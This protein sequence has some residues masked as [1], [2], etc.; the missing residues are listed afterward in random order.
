MHEGV[1]E[2][3]VK[4]VGFLRMKDAQG[5]VVGRLFVQRAE[6]SEFAVSGVI[7]GYI[8]GRSG[9]LIESLLIGR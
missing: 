9:F 3:K 6:E 1:N 7:V 8:F 2:T 4:L 5:R